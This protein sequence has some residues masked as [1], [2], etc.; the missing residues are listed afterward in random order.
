MLAAP[1]LGSSMA[2]LVREVLK[3]GA[4]SDSILTDL[5]ISAMPGGS[6][7]LR[8]KGLVPILSAVHAPCARRGSVPS[9][10]WV[11]EPKARE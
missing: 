10:G 6:E 1:R 2:D 9:Y 4:M 11:G 3:A 7:S 8:R 5:F